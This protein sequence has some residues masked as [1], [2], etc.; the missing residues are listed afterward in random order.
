MEERR[1]TRDFGM[2]K[3][4]KQPIHREDMSRSRRRNLPASLRISKLSNLGALDDADYLALARGKLDLPQLDKVTVKEIS[5]LAQEMQTL[6]QGFARD[7]Y[8][9]QIHGLIREMTPKGWRDIAKDIISAPKAFQASFDLSGILRQGAVLD[10]RF[11][12]E[13]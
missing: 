8:A 6:P 4:A 10:A 1:P 3:T 2:K 11:P 13:A 12:K 7:K 9:Q 5:R